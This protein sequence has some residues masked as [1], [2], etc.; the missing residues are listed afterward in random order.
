MEHEI[1]EVQGAKKPCLTLWVLQ[2]SR[3]PYMAHHLPKMEVDPENIKDGVLS[4]VQESSI[5]I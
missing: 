5:R 1:E 2:V 3:Y 4:E